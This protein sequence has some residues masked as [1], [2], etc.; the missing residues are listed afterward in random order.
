M[1][2]HSSRGEGGCKHAFSVYSIARFGY[3][4]WYVDFSIPYG[5]DKDGCNSPV[6]RNHREIQSLSPADIGYQ[7]FVSSFEING[8]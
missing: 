4:I 8:S 2:S 5:N 3:Y 7:K 6:A 1:A